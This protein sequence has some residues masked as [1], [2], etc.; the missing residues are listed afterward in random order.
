MVLLIWLN[1]SNS[2]GHIGFCIETKYE[3][4][5][6]NHNLQFGFNQDS[7]RKKLIHFHSILHVI[8]TMYVKTVS[9]GCDHVT[10]P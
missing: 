10:F 8:C 6:I 4:F 7:E 5:V 1:L 2:G 9:C 3:S